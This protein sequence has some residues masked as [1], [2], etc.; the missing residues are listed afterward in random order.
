MRKDDH[1][2]KFI[3]D[4]ILKE[5]WLFDIGKK[6]IMCVFDDR[7][8]VVNMWRRNGLTCLQVADGDF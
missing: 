2:E 8:K 4:E 3:S 6:N 5:N 1:S 7:D